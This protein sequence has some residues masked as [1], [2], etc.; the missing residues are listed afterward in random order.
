MSISDQHSNL[1]IVPYTNANSVQ[2]EN[3]NLAGFHEVN[4]RTVEKQLEEHAKPLTN[5]GQQLNWR[6][7]TMIMA[8]KVLQKT[9]IGI[10]KD[11]R[12]PWTK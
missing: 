1:L 4:E 3:A 6:R 7:A 11:Y 2:G 12:G 8:I 9:R 5:E 10:V